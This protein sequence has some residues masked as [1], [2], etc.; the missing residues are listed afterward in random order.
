MSEFA[1]SW[2][3]EYC[4]VSRETFDALDRFVEFLSQEN[5]TQ[6]LISRGT[7]GDIW[8]RHVLDSAQLLRFASNPKTWLDLGTGAGFPG[9]IIAALSPARVTM[10]EARPKRVDFLRRAA[11]VL[12]LPKN[13]EIICA[14]V[15]RVSPQAFDV[16]SARAFA[17]LSKLLPLAL[18][19]SKQ[20][21]FWLL[22]KGRSAASE[23]EAEK[24]L[25]QG[26]FRVEPSLTD[27]EAGIIVAHGV[28]RRARG[29]RR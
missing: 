27:S 4:D 25:W 13:T 17:P 19:F 22:P 5:E 20:D 29:A 7:V 6:N 26:S 12:A 28:S 16:I 24:P 1:K 14:K 21:T 3:T 2:L 18:P 10:I 9:L 15:E 23:L 8:A 11:E